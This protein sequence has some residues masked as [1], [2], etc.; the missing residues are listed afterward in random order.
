MMTRRAKEDDMEL[1]RA[2]EKLDKY[3]KRFDNGKAQ[4]IEPAHV[5]KVI[6]KLETKAELLRA[7]IAETE[8]EAKKTRLER[9]LD[10]LREQKER[11]HWLM[12]QISES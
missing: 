10:T 4:K 12:D 5:E 8:K 9:K 11:A 7:E 3:F 6:R 1:E 2:I